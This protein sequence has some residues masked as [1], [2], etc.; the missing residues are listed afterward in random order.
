MLTLS[1]PILWCVIRETDCTTYSCKVLIFSRIG[2]I[3]ASSCAF[4]CNTKS[5]GQD[6]HLKKLFRDIVTSRYC[7]DIQTVVMR[8]KKIIT[9]TNLKK[10]I[11]L[12]VLVLESQAPR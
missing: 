11:Y 9:V 1:S 5:T 4:Y 6:G 12:L 2:K 8:L 7:I 3:C 10:V